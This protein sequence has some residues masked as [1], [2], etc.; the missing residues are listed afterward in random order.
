M[1]VVYSGRRR[2]DRVVEQELEARFLDLD[3]LL[4]TADVVSLHCPLTE[5]TRYLI[6]AERLKQMKP[7]AF[8]VNTT[9][10]PV[11]DEAALAAALRDG[12]IAGAGLDV[13]EKEPEVH[14]DLLPLDNVVMIPHLGSA[15]VETRT[16]MALLAAENTVAVLAGREPPTPVN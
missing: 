6:T 14:A 11:I 2:A 9:R 5:E 15:T 4:A 13:F 7:S 1:D 16:A 10:G 3:E 12:V 8:L